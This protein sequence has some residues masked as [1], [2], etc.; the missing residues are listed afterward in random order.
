MGKVWPKEIHGQAW[1]QGVP[2]ASVRPKTSMGKG[3]F[4]EIH[5]QRLAQGDP[6]AGVGPRRSM[7]KGWPKEIHGLNNFICV[8]E[9]FIPCQ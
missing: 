7:G 4:K 3:W 2:W 1:A 5:G 6:W 9:I 8:N